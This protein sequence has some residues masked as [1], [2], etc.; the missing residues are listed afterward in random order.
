MNDFNITVGKRL[1]IVRNIFNEGGKL[2]ADQFAFLMG[3]TRDRITN[4]ELGRAA[5]P[6]RLLYEL[7]NRGI[8]PVYIITGEGSVFTETKEGIEFLAKI[9][10]KI[11]SG[12]INDRRTI[13]TINHMIGNHSYMTDKPPI[14][15]HRVA[16]GR[17]DSTLGQ[18]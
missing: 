17:L 18:S 1:R 8:N 9:V 14:F 13:R 2:T 6:V 4:Y 12:L 16:A 11:N 7:Y 3:E 5:L 10:N 15:V